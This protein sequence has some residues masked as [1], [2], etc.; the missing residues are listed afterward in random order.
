MTAT[1]VQRLQLEQGQLDMILHG[2]SKGDYEAVAASANTE[3]LQQNALVKTLV[4][5][6]PD[7][8]S[9]ALCPRARH[10]AQDSTK[11]P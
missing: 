8:R 1:A 11:P 6:N 4:M 9:S 5:V 7:S 3:V 2:L 10:S